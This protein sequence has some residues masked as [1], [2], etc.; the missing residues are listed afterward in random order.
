MS[1]LSVK[2]LEVEFKIRDAQSWF[3][4]APASLKAVNRISFELQ[5]GETLGIV[6]ESGCGKST[7]A[8]AIIGLAQPN[9]G[10]ILWNGEELIGL[11]EKAMRLKR[12]DIQMI[13]QDPLASLNPRMT[14]GEIIAEP[15]RTFYPGLGKAES[16][17]RVKAMMQKVGLLPN[18]INRYPHEFSGGQCQ[19]IGIAR[20]LIVEPK[21]IICD[22]PVSALDVSIQAQVINLLKQ[23]QTEMGLALIFIAHDLSVVKHI[24]DR[25]LVMY[26]GHAVELGGYGEIYGAPTHP[27][28]QALMSAVPLP[29]PDAERNK[30][31]Q[32]LPGDLPS[33]INPPSGCVFRT[34]CPQADA[35]CA[36]NKPMLAGNLQHQ[37]A[38]LKN[39]VAVS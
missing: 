6:G 5:A 16:E 31:I 32:L 23:V 36:D 9:S 15:L 27:Y 37:V 18:Q 26:L 25:V 12:K 38:C 39:S 2:D 30:T 10:S 28:T 21:L 1:L 4:Q 22:E 17:N 29:D 19:R 3:W 34:R 35:G 11:S 24:S 33:P 8:R 13:F 7:L 14:L 20:A